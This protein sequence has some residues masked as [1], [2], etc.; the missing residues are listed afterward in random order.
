MLNYVARRLLL[1]V[2]ILFGVALITFLLMH[3]VPGDHAQLVA[4]Y[5]YG[6][7]DFSTDELKAVQEDI[8]ADQPLHRQFILW[9]NH[10]LRGDLGYSFI[11]GR[12]VTAEIL[13][14]VP[15]TLELATFSFLIT[16][17]IAFPLG[18]VSARRPYSWLDNIAMVSSLIGVAIPN[19]WLGLLL[20]LVFSLTLGLLPV[21]GSG[22]LAH[23]ILPSITLGSG[24]AAV[25]TRLIRAS[26]L[27]VLEQDYIATARSK[28]LGEG[29][30]FR[31]HAL[32]NALIP[33]VT[34]L[35]L[36]LN[37][38]IGGTVIIETVFARPG[39]G[40]LIVDAIQARDM[41]VLQGCVL[42]L[43]LTFSMI[44][45]LV[46]ISYAFLDPRI[47]YGGGQR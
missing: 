3:V 10:V 19:F 12:P 7:D 28:G 41:P 38:L 20:I 15:A 32:R 6:F 30:V 16:V 37:H 45:L 33:V 36:Q 23:L 25:S 46:D 24:M 13:A 31:R 34:V 11:S 9:L 5:R 22:D 39:V 42:F 47:R 40:K 35:G 18:I 4:T 2:F 21:A 14:R 8:G 44:N 26:L 17:L 43:A 1:L 27:D 29:V